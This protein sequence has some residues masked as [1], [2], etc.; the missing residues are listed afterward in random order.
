MA[1]QIIDI[2]SK[3]F[4]NLYIYRKKKT[5]E[6]VQISQTRPPQF[7][8][9]RCTNH[10]CVADAF[11]EHFG[12][13]LEHQKIQN[14]AIGH[15]SYDHFWYHFPEKKSEKGIPQNVNKLIPKKCRPMMPKGSRMM[16]KWM[17]KSM[18]F[19]I[20]QKMRKRSK[21]FFYNIKRGSGLLKTRVKS[22]Q[23]LCKIDA[24][25]MHARIMQNDAKTKPKWEPKL[26]QGLEKAGQKNTLKKI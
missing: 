13:A 1:T 22:V 21:L 25:K 4:P 18:L 20:F 6:T 16:P 19:H 7:I 5:A 8:P 11:L 12:R 9:N 26:M 15:K 23:N 2:T 3:P 24:W 10:C 14:K 17:P